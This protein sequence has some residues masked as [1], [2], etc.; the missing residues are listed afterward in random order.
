MESV[1]VADPLHDHLL[2]PQH[3]CLGFRELARQPC[4]EVSED[5]FRE[6]RC[7]SVGVLAHFTALGPRSEWSDSLASLARRAGQRFAF[8]H[9][10]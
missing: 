4:P 2:V 6:V 3:R 10:T 8:S 5:L 9:P 7:R 1:P